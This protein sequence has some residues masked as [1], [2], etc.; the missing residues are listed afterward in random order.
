MLY[1]PVRISSAGF[2]SS[3]IVV[4]LEGV[5]DNSAHQQVKVQTMRDEVRTF[6]L[7]VAA[8]KEPARGHVRRLAAA[9][10]TA[11]PGGRRRRLLRRRR[12]LKL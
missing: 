5:E 1:L 11:A 8:S 7:F 9:S 2:S 10:V 4:R 12:R 3:R 6:C